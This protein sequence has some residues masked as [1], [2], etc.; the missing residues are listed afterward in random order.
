MTVQVTC[1]KSS[2]IQSGA[3]CVFGNFNK[4]CSTN[5]VFAKKTSVVGAY[6]FPHLKLVSDFITRCLEGIAGPR[7][8]Q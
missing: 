7:W 8:K 3:L 5:P 2:S 1:W 4:A 6:A